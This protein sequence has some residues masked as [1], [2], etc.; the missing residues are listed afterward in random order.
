MK[1]GGVDPQSLPKEHILV[2]PRGDQQ[3]VF[4]AVGVPDMDEFETLCPEPKPP[5]KLTKDGWEPNEGDENWKTQMLHHGRRRMAYM[6]IKTLAASDIEWDTVDPDSPKTWTNWE[7]DLREA[8]FSQV[9]INR[10]TQLVW[11]ANCLDEEKLE[12]ARK[13]FLRGQQQESGESSGLPTEPEST[14]S[15]EPASA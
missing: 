5:G 1:I 12:R 15:G 7:T 10:I 13:V 4:R 2:L 3:V 6:A 14:P 11:E 8:G 9:E